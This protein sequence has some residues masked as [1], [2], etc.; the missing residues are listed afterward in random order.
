M[1]PTRNAEGPALKLKRAGGIEAVAVHVPGGRCSSS[2]Q[3]K[4]PSVGMIETPWNDPDASKFFLFIPKNEIDPRSNS[5]PKS[6]F[7]LEFTTIPNSPKTFLSPLYSPITI[8]PSS[9][10]FQSTID[11]V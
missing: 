7:S 6:R 8:P 4:A 2:A 5:T 9:T 10:P 3:E 1:I 11:L